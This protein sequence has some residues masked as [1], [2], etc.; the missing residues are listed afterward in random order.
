MSQDDG[1]REAGR[2]RRSPVAL[3]GSAF[4]VYLALSVLL[5][6]HVWS[7]HPTSVAMCGCN[8]PSLF[9]WFL[10]WPAYAL[11]HGH[12]LFYSTALFHPAGINLLANTSVLA[13]G[14]PLAPIT[15]LFGPV[16]TL[17]VAST[18]A[19]ALS[20][21]A[22]CWLLR[23]WVHWLP[24]AFVGGLVF[25]FSPFVIVNLAVSHLMLGFL[26]LVPL[27]VACLDELL[28]RQRRRPAA[29]GV[30]LGLLV[31][32]QFFVSTEVLVVVVLVGM[33][34]VV[35]LVAHCALTCPHEIARRA[36]HAVRGLGAAAGVAVVLLGYPL[37]FTLAGPAHLSGLV[38]P[39]IRPG[40]GNLALSDLWHL[41][42][43][44]AHALSLFAGYQGPALPELSYLGPGFLVVLA[45]G[46][47]IWWRDRRLWFFGSLGV[48]A[49]ILSLGVQSYWTPWRLLVGVPIVQ[50]VLTG[51]I[52]TI[53]LLCFAVMLA[54]V[55][56]RTRDAVLAW[57]DRL[58]AHRAR[59]LAGMR[60]GAIGVGNVL[61]ASTA[62]VVA[63]VAAVPMATA[64][65]GNVPLTTEAVTLPQWFIEVGP[66]VPPHQVVLTFPPPITG[67]SAMTW[68][69][70]DSLH[71]ALATGSGPESIPQR[72]G[73]ERAGQAV[74]TAA[75]SAFPTLMPA[76]R[77]NVVAVR[78]ALRGWG[79]TY[80]VIPDPAVLVPHADR[81]AGTAW[82]LGFF[83]LAVGRP[84]QYRAGAWV[85][86]D[87]RSP[88]ARR[89][90]SPQD[91]VRCTAAGRFRGPS[92]DAVPDCVSA[93]SFP[94]SH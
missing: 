85:W 60:G 75:A 89:A 18:L 29:T 70:V 33:I 16:A 90:I 74:I 8:D 47:S 62:L 51:R 36:P 24:A 32:L 17:N 28:V 37:W 43:L 44:N 80:V 31:A 15:W 19:P 63:A 22:M 88:G 91:F 76:T 35:L 1:P 9:V 77:R 87:V 3:L 23:R 55:I 10:E 14:V 2:F 54:I 79:V 57:V 11:A 71:F 61:A 93:A 42:F 66:H 48:V 52:L 45:I 78:D 6:W 67:A 56:D 86:S 26:A 58:A 7:T 40:S 81:D 72:A 84:P 46:V 50:N 92:R 53:T 5:W 13:I 34:G 27:I 68:Q 12:N 82:A 38:W 59:W 94:S 25:G 20:A 65:A 64:I 41:T 83:T 30:A 49:V 21:L 39:A 69:A 4:A 73:S